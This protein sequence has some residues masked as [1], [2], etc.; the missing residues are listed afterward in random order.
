M[1]TRA[2]PGVGNPSLMVSGA[3]SLGVRVRR[4]RDPLGAR[5]TRS[6]SPKVV[7]PSRRELVMGG[8]ETARSGRR[9]GSDEP[10]TEGGVGEP[11]PRLALPN[12]G[13]IET[14][15]NP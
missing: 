2:E 14:L 15:G 8:R 7:G 4:E 6:A 1:G 9:Y 10:L 5:R 12:R 13:V 3:T 11:P